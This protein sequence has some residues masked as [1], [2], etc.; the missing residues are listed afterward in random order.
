MEDMVDKKFILWTFL[1]L[2][3]GTLFWLA[4]DFVSAPKLVDRVPFTLT[5][6]Y[7]VTTSEGGDLF[8]QEIELAFKSNGSKAKLYPRHFT[9][10]N[11]SL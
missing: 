10:R 4:S 7:T 2:S 5:Q 1:I 3:A 11:D 6:T 8:H 9:R